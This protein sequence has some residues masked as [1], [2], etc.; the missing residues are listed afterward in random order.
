MTENYTSKESVIPET[1]Q[2]EIYKLTIELVPSSCWYNNLRKALP[3]SIWKGLR[4]QVYADY[5]HKCA[6]CEAEGRGLNCHEVWEYADE[7]HIQ[8]LKGFVALCNLCHH[9][10]HLGQAGILASQGHLDFDEVIDHFCEVNE[11]EE[12]DFYLARREAFEKWVERSQHEWTTNFGEYQS[13]L[14]LV[15]T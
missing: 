5:D 4:L 7:I 11:C 12:D 14:D 1:K 13:L 6:V 3:G 9:V 2:I 15:K 10:K 8:T